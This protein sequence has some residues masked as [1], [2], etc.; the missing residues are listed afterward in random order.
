MIEP[1]ITCPN[2]KPEDQAVFG[3]FSPKDLVAF[4]ALL[5]RFIE[6][7]ERE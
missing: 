1:T 7:F 3:A 2:G 5:A 6:A 4:R